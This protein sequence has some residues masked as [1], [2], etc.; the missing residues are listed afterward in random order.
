VVANQDI[1]DVHPRVKPNS[2]ATSLTIT[3]PPGYPRRIVQFSQ[4]KGSLVALADDGSPWLL[5]VS[6]YGGSASGWIWLDLPSLPPAEKP[7]AAPAPAPAP[8]RE[9]QSKRPRKANEQICALDQ[10]VPFRDLADAFQIARRRGVPVIVI[11]KALKEAIGTSSIYQTKAADRAAAL[12]ALR[13]L[14]A[15]DG[16]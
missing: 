1:S 3:L 7:P 13:A 15:G 11:G 10:P 5:A 9:P 14:A 6:P 4:H 2:T 12:A 8:S 16:R